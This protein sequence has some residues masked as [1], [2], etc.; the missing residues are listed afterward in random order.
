MRDE[1]PFGA[2][3]ITARQI[4]GATLLS[5][6]YLA[7]DARLDRVRTRVQLLM[8]KGEFA[9]PTSGSGAQIAP[10]PAS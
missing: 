9:Q 4:S 5:P 6:D 8:E 2:S 7:I 10:G 1:G 3:A